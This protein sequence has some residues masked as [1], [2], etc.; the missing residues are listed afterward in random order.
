ML[1]EL[2]NNDGRIT[3][4]SETYQVGAEE[5]D[6]SNPDVRDFL[7]LNDEN[8]SPDAYLDQ[9]D[10]SISRIIEDLIELLIDK[11]VI[12]F[13]DLPNGAQGKLLTRKLARGLI[14][15][16]LTED[17]IGDESETSIL[18]DEDELL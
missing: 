16:D 15:G 1:Y 3:G 10:K 18:S 9:S 11:N 7:S 8:F 6:M 12:I 4:L 2:L 5:V 13:T 17:T 14:R